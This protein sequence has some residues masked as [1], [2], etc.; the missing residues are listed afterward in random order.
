VERRLPHGLI[1]FVLRRELVGYRGG[2]DDDVVRMEAREQLA[3][4]EPDFGGICT[5]Q[6]VEVGTLGQLL[7]LI[8]FERVDFPQLNL[9]PL[10][11]LFL[12]QPRSLS[13][14]A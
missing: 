9:R 8:R 11:H 4:V 10:R 2:D 7:E 12:R 5:D 1:G 13:S 6:A 3:S 14:F